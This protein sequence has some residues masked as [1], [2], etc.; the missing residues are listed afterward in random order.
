VEEAVE[1]IAEIY[2]SSDQSSASASAAA[3]ANS[4]DKAVETSP[5]VDENFKQKMQHWEERDDELAAREQS[6]KKMEENYRHEDESRLESLS[7]QVNFVEKLA[8]RKTQLIYY[9]EEHERAM[10]PQ[11]ETSLP[12]P[13]SLS[14]SES[15]LNQIDDRYSFSDS[16]QRFPSSAR[17]SVEKSQVFDATAPMKLSADRGRRRVQATTNLGQRQYQWRQQSSV[18]SLSEEV[19]DITRQ[20]FQDSSSV[21]SS[22]APPLSDDSNPSRSRE[23]PEVVTR[24]LT[25]SPS[26]RLRHST[27]SLISVPESIDEEMEDVL[28]T[29]RFSVSDLDIRPMITRDMTKVS[30]SGR[31][32]WSMDE[33][34][35]ASRAVA[36]PRTMSIATSCTDRGYLSGSQQEVLVNDGTSS[37]SS[38]HSDRRAKVTVKNANVSVSADQSD[39]KKITPRSGPLSKSQSFGGKGTGLLN[40]LRETFWQQSKAAKEQDVSST[41]PQRQLKGLSASLQ[42]KSGKPDKLTSA[43]SREKNT[44]PKK[45]SAAATDSSASGVKKQAKKAG[46]K[47]DMKAPGSQRSP[48]ELKS[49]PEKSSKVGFLKN[50]LKGR[51]KAAAAAGGNSK[52]DVPVQLFLPKGL[53]STGN[54]VLLDSERTTDTVH[55]IEG[56]MAEVSQTVDPSPWT[57][58]TEAK[59]SHGSSLADVRSSRTQ[60][61]LA[62]A[63]ESSQDSEFSAFPAAGGENRHSLRIL[64]NR[65]SVL[66]S[67]E[68]EQLR[69]N[70][71]DDSLNGQDDFSAVCNVG[72]RS[73]SDET[74]ASSLSME[75][76]VQQ[77]KTVNSDD[78]VFSDDSLVSSVNQSNEDL[79]RSAVVESGFVQPAAAAGIFDA[80]DEV[81]DAGRRVVHVAEFEKL[82]GGESGPIQT[83]ASQ[84]DS[85]FPAE[86]ASSWVEKSYQQSSMCVSTDV[87]IGNRGLSSSAA[88]MRHDNHTSHNMK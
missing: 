65:L 10:Y 74:K 52:N 86:N 88:A 32:R 17:F 37:S 81:N 25:R 28:L 50:I 13:N 30:S 79:I 56:S 83:A 61:S 8:C 6:L 20:M 73:K 34:Y 45:T 51:S 27:L 57:V 67:G 55:Q 35:L 7:A 21:R 76:F 42:A 75:S 1:L 39:S 41:P 33:R 46:S 18:D 5:E 48:A 11:F 87:T 85:L 24:Q 15:C 44:V 9:I 19:P 72:Y 3:T 77:A 59:L 84:K 4:Q 14:L 70:F 66:V 22:S 58:S 36:P 26:P 12:L 69:D 64:P 43:T 29:S 71:S 47:L 82:V 68:V 53:P 16:R 40:R 63:C 49:N 60:D 23:T 31:V 80:G 54:D 2:L 38:S 62:N 78:E